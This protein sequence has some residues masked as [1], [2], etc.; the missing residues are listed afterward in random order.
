MAEQN[1]GKQDLTL[2]HANQ[3]EP[4]AADAGGSDADFGG[5]AGSQHNDWGHS[6]AG[7][8]GN[9]QA[10]QAGQAGVDVG[11]NGAGNSAGH[12]GGGNIGG[13]AGGQH[14]DWGHSPVD[15]GNAQSSDS[16]GQQSAGQPSSGQAPRQGVMPG[17]EMGH[18]NRSGDD[19]AK[20]G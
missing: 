9:A 16:S 13:V 4:G 2:N 17:E 19:G 8:L 14:N 7:G 3:E 20:Q 11:G 12:A 1:D 18:L 15:A 6:Q 10:G 5:A